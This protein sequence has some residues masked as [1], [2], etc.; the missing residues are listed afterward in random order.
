MK[1]FEHYKKQYETKNNIKNN[2]GNKIPH[3]KYIP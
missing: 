3:H 1:K 2:P